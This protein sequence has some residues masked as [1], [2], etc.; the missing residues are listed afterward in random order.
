MNVITPV[1]NMGCLYQ[2]IQVPLTTAVPVSPSFVQNDDRW[3]AFAAYFREEERQEYTTR[4]PNRGPMPLFPLGACIPFS[5]DLETILAMSY[6]AKCKD[7]KLILTINGKE[8]VLYRQRNDLLE[9]QKGIHYYLELSFEGEEWIIDPSWKQFAG[10]RDKDGRFLENDPYNKRLKDEFP[11]ILVA[12]RECVISL[13]TAL[14]KEAACELIAENICY[15]EETDRVGSNLIAES[16]EDAS[17]DVLHPHYWD[18]KGD[19]IEAEKWEKFQKIT[20]NSSASFIE[21]SK[22]VMQSSSQS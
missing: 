15:W 8:A 5:A 13:M 12:K 1:P 4:T 10:K 14:S 16:I 6:P 17:T 21:F 3:E 7:K 20:G 22:T 18:P 19:Y 2:T 9:K 11:D